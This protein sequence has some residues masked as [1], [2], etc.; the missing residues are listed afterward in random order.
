MDQTDEFSGKAFPQTVNLRATASWKKRFTETSL[1]ATKEFQ[2]LK[3][4]GKRMEKDLKQTEKILNYLESKYA[5]EPVKKC[6][7]FTS[8]C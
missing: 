2:V 5:T 1:T 8:L 4:L 3:A 6:V 7:K